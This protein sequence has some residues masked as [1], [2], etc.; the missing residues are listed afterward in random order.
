[1]RVLVASDRGVMFCNEWIKWF[2]ARGVAYDEILYDLDILDDYDVLLMWFINYASLNSMEI[3]KKAKPHIKIAM[4]TDDDW[5]DYTTNN[6]DIPE[7]YLKYLLYADLIFDCN[8]LTHLYL[9]NKGYPS[10]FVSVLSPK[11]VDVSNV[12]P[13]SY[14]ERKKLNRGLGMIHGV[15]ILANQ[16]NMINFIRRIKL[17]P[18]WIGSEWVKGNQKEG[19]E[20][21]EYFPPFGHDIDY[22]NM[23]NQGLIGVIDNYA[24]VSRFCHECAL[25]GIPTVGTRTA[26]TLYNY[27][28]ELTCEYGKLDILYDKTVKLISEEEYYTS[29]SRRIK[30]KA[31]TFFS[32]EESKLRLTKTIKEFWGSIYEL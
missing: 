6:L 25:L 10:A 24:G 5:Y 29:V 21:G 22:I 15:K 1:M 16:S 11:T 18:L 13:L 12:K 31:Q 14:Y 7:N 27:A 17:K 8:Y 32:V 23:L 3:I 28:P 26:Y 4:Q 20:E 30:E 19:L 2:N 9:K